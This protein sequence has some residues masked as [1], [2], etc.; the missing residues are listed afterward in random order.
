MESALEYWRKRS[1]SDTE[2]QELAY[3]RTST[4]MAK[5]AS[6]PPNKNIGSCAVCGHESLD[7]FIVREMQIG[8]REAFEYGRCNRCEAIIRLSKIND[9]GRYYP[10]NYYAFAERGEQPLARSARSWFR[11]WRDR[12]LLT[13]SLDPVGRI[14]RWRSQESID[15]YR[16]LGKC[17]INLSSSVLD[18]GCGSGYLLQRMAEVGFQNLL[19]ID[20]FIPETTLLNFRNP[21]IVRGILSQLRDRTFDLIM[22]HH[23]FEHNEDPINELRLARELLSRNGS[24]LVRQ[25]VSDSEAFRSYGSN[26][27][28]LDAPR[29]AVVHSL[30][31]MKLI[32]QQCGLTIKDIVWDSTDQQFWASEQYAQGV[33]MY[34]ERSYLQN[35]EH[36]LFSRGQIL[37]WKRQAAVLN[38]N[39]VGDQA[40]FYLRREE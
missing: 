30:T 36:S 39:S 13:K 22:M 25:P 37:A 5:I 7:T 21:K 11:N 15:L 12:A 26:W 33:P 8:L 19:G 1:V 16:I 32:V 31:S 29:H 40:A 23:S 17:Q 4:L 6:Q 2:N 28:Q 14:F 34:D 27:F 10:E 9:M 24:I 18:V 38:K 3:T 35:P 20:L